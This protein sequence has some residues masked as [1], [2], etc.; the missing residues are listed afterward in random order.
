MPN[1][2]TKAPGPWTISLSIIDPSPPTWL[3]SRL[4]ITEPRRK[5]SALPP[6]WP[7]PD[8]SAVASLLSSSSPETRREKPP[9]QFRLQTK[10]A[11][12]HPPM[13]KRSKK[14]RQGL[15]AQFADKPASSGLQY[16]YVCLGFSQMVR[17]PCD[18]SRFSDSAY[19]APNG[20]LQ[21]TMEARLAKPLAN[22]DCVIC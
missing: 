6:P 11:Q 14:R 3:D 20:T 13:A 15:V 9:I 16:P 12:L 7:L 22:A 5:F 8:G 18:R 10:S 2:K 1:K 19:Y 21:V 17:S 4:V